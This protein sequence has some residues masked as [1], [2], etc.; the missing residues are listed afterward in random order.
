MQGLLLGAAA[1]TFLNTRPAAWLEGA[2]ATTERLAVVGAAALAL[3]VVVVDDTDRWMYRGGFTVAA[4]ASLL[5]VVGAW[6]PN[7]GSRVQR[8]LAAGPLP[9]IGRI[10]YGL[11]L[12]H[13]PVYVFM[14]PERTGLTGSSL[15][16]ARVAATFAVATCSYHLVERPIR[17]GAL[18][19]R[20]YGMPSAGL[21][22]AG[23]LLAVVLTTAPTGGR[24]AAP[25]EGGIASGP[26][27]AG[28]PKVLL[29]GDSVAG[30]LGRGLP[31]GAP[32]SLTT[33]TFPGCGLV[34]GQAVAPNG[35]ERAPESCATA[36]T[37]IEQA[38]TTVRPDV[39]IVLTGSW[40]LYDHRVGSELLTIGSQGY[41]DHIER[42]LDALRAVLGS[43]GGRVIVLTPPCPQ[44]REGT[45]AASAT[46]EVFT[47][48]RSA[49]LGEVFRAF[50][51]E[52][53]EAVTLGDLRELVCP[54]DEWQREVD[55]VELH[56]D[57]VHYTPD[58]AAL[59]WDWLLTRIDEA[60]G[61]AA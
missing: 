34:R 15:L 22:T 53:S 40:E 12:W 31:E 47:K 41:A 39:S 51:A 25:E 28:A 17:A 21:V 2:R 9:A 33:A 44:P 57:G 8:L 27:V 11:Y 61:R 42:E 13:W 60:L 24:T 52:R 54:D 49:W 16:V 37:S 35:D 29:V 7:P 50:G 23:I 10:S 3:M 59:V 55:G 1:A 19:T 4:I 46:G 43:A 26:V 38:V 45:T 6:H 20:R 30:S 5:L 14:T 36:W 58:G 32:V 56:T 48:E 18:S